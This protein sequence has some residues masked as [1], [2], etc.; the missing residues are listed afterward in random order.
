MVPCD[1]NGAL[2]TIAHV[3]DK[4]KESRP[5]DRI[6]RKAYSPPVLVAYGGLT[7]PLLMAGLTGSANDGKILM[8][9]VPG[10]YSK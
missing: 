9:G 10:R 6:S 5:S 3:T 7:V 1:R 4:E 8:G 2:E